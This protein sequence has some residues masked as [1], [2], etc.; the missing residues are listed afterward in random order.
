MN[1][2]VDGFFRLIERGSYIRIGHIS[3]IKSK[4]GF[5]ESCQRLVN[6]AIQIAKRFFTDDELFRGIKIGTVPII[7]PLVKR[8]RNIVFKKTANI[9]KYLVPNADLRVGTERNVLGS[10]VG[11]CRM[12]ER[13]H[14]LLPYVIELGIADA[15]SLATRRRHTVDQGEIKSVDRIKG[16]RLAAFHIFKQDIKFGMHGITTFNNI[17]TVQTRKYYNIKYE[18]VKIFFKENKKIYEFF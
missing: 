9:R 5:L 13:D 11:E 3:D 15:I 7:F 17:N 16:E 8:Y 12:V 18:I 1:G 14:R 4:N 10:I 2:V 6:S